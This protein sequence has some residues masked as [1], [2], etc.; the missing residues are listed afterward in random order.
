MSHQGK[1]YLFLGLIVFPFCGAGLYSVGPAFRT[2]YAISTFDVSK[3]SDF[4]TLD[5]SDRLKARRHLQRYL[6]DHNAYVPLEDIGW[7]DEGLVR[8]SASGWAMQRHCDRAR[9]HAWVPLR[10][11]IPIIGEKVVEWCWKPQTK[12]A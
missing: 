7:E 1:S 12:T 2:L 6:S 11:K 4:E 3:V 10:F 8:E 5:P 9:L